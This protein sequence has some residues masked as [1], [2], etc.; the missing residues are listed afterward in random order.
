MSGF[1]SSIGQQH[2]QQELARAVVLIAAAM[3]T[4]RK[5]TFVASW[6]VRHGY[7]WRDAE[8]SDLGFHLE[9]STFDP[10]EWQ[11]DGRDINLDRYRVQLLSVVTG[12]KS[13]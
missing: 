10:K 1:G 7:Y 11:I 8:L 13:A 3:A 6:S 9:Q 12:E 2:S 4:G 5:V